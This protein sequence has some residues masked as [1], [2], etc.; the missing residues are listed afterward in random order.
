MGIVVLVGGPADGRRMELRA[1]Y[2]TRLRVSMPPP[3]AEPRLLP[4]QGVALALDI[5]IA[6]YELVELHVAS[7][8]HVFY[9]HESL[10]VGD[11]VAQLLRGY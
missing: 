7:A 5:P 2:P 9:R 10:T 8:R 4:Y 1:M 11:A 6:N 3:L